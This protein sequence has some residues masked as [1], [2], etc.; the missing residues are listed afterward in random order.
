MNFI[1]AEYD[2]IDASLRGC[3]I[4]LFARY[5]AKIHLI[6]L[7]VPYKQWIQQN[8]QRKYRVPDDAMARMLRKLEFPTIDE[9]HQ[10]SY[11]INGEFQALE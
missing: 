7:E 10:V 5:Q 2:V 3:I 9:A 8:K 1:F 4:N 11:F 6:Y